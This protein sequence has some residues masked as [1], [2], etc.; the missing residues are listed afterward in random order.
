MKKRQY[1]IDLLKYVIQRD[2][3]IIDLTKYNL[4]MWSKLTRNTRINFTCH[5]KKEFEK[6]F[7]MLYKIGA[8]CYT[9]THNLSIEK[10]KQTSLKHFNVEYPSQSNEFKQ[11]F[12]ET[13]LNKY[14]VEHALQ[15]KEFKEKAKLTMLE[16]YGVEYN[17]QSKEF[18]ERYKQ[19][20]LKKYGV[21]YSMQNAQI[22]EKSSFKIKKFTFPDGSIIKLQG[23][24]PIAI[25]L[26]LSKGYEQKD[27]ITSKAKVPEI[28]YND[29]DN[30]KH[31]YYCDIYI[32]SEN[33]IIEV[34]S[35]WT[36]NKY[37]H[38]NTLKAETCKAE[39][40]NFEFWI[41]DDTKNH[42][43]EIISA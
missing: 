12:K 10:K 29:L 11:K 24:E 17:L 5:C 3:C 34:K 1:N 21:E 25:Q 41:I 18:K 28:W 9:C 23:Y 6:E 16:R 39:C 20:M 38:I 37:L 8:F 42:N 7:R 15:N 13:M 35:K 14:N 27:I 40:Y 31:R 36:Y 30:K 2:K 32:P 4:P 19:T 22:F 26:L 43:C 33:K